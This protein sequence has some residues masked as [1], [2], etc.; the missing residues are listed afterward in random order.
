MSAPVCSPCRALGLPGGFV[1]QCAWMC[2]APVSG[3]ECEFDS[4]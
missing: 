2:T 1:L 3:F 4:I